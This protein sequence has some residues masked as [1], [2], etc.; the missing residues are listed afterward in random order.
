MEVDGKPTAV[1]NR[2]EM[3]VSSSSQSTLRANRTKYTAQISFDVI[4]TA[5]RCSIRDSTLVCLLWALNQPC[6]WLR[7]RG[8]ILLL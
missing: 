8:S 2:K 1:R 7:V 6:V 4:C 3:R 5:I